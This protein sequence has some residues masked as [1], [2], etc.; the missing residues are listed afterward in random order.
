MEIMSDATLS[1][2]TERHREE[3]QRQVSIRRVNGGGSSRKTIIASCENSLRHRVEFD[4]R[5]TTGALL[6]TRNNNRSLI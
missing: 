5:C 2:A 1:G 6:S 3:V 4:R